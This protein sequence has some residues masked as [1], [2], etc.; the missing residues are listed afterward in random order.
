[1]PGV[2]DPNAWKDAFGNTPPTVLDTSGIYQYLGSYT[3]ASCI[4]TPLTYIGSGSVAI[5]TQLTIPWQ[6]VPGTD[7]GGAILS[8]STD[9]VHWSITTL[10]AAGS[11]VTSSGT[12]NVTLGT[13]TALLIGVGATAL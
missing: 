9:S 1:M 6:Y 2:N 13:A 12:L 3:V 10:A 7:E 4:D 11:N 8:I 5:P